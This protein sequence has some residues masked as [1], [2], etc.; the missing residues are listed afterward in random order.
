[1][2]RKGN[3]EEDLIVK[4]IRIPSSQKSMIRKY[5]RQYGISKEL[6]YDEAKKSVNMLSY[7]YEVEVSNKFGFNKVKV[8]VKLSD[9]LFS[10]EEIER[11]VDTIYK[12]MK[13]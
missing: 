13:K 7:E 3:P 8:N 4:K 5:L 12:Q 6:L 11:I 1:M 9:I 2:L 10:E